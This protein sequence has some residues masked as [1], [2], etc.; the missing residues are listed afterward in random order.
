LL[1]RHSCHCR[2]IPPLQ[3]RDGTNSPELVILCLP[4]TALAFTGVTSFPST[5]DLGLVSRGS[6][7]LNTRLS[8][9]SVLR[10][11]LRYTPRAIRS[12]GIIESIREKPKTSA[13]TVS[14]RPMA[15]MV[16]TLRAS[17]MGPL[18][19]HLV[20]TSIGSE[21]RKIWEEAGRRETHCVPL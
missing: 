13:S 16:A 11:Q 10:V 3:Y 2:R 17:G 21:L 12:P 4:S 19:W 9:Q 1:L 5:T 14:S 8:A 15:M 20:S 6:P 18:G 7:G